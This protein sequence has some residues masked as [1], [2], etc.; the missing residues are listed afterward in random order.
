MKTILTTLAILGTMSLSAQT[1]EKQVIGATGGTA[2]AGT[3]IVTATVGEVSVK[4]LSGT[5]TLTQG[6]Q[7]G[8]TGPV[9]VEEIK[10]DANY[11]LYPNPT[12]NGAK[13][14]ITTLNLDADASILLYSKEGKLL[15][16]QKVI[17]TSGVKSTVTIDL[18]SKEK[19]VYFV[20]ILDSKSEISKTLRVV[21]Q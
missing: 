8:S 20:K 12:T 5:L 2:T 21:K 15:S 7:Q 4:T 6:Y 9:S 19:G 14:E 11:K 1:I 13:L 16:T 10:V 17:L 3:V 18:K